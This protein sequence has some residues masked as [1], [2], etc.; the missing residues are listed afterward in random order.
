MRLAILGVIAIGCGS[1]AS[2]PAAPPSQA[3]G[4]PAARWV[5]ARPTYVFASRTVGEAQRNLRD[6]IDM[7][8]TAAGYDLHDAT[9]AVEGLFGVDPLQGASLAAIGVDLHGSWA[10]FSEAL[11]PTLVVHLAAPAQM[12]AFLE[13]QRQRGLV[14]QSTIVDTTEVFSAKLVGGVTLRWA[15]AGDWMWVHLALPLGPEDATS[16]FR[17]SHG[18]HGD[19]WTSNWAWA[20]RAAGAAAGVIGVLD[21]HGLNGLNGVN[22]LNGAIAGAIARIPG[23]LACTKLVEPVGRVAVAVAGDDHHVAAR[24]AV[25]VGSTTGIRSLILPAPSGWDATAAHAAIAAQWNLDLTAARSWLSPCLA[26]AGGQLAPLDEIPVRAARGM[27]LGFDPGAMSGSGAVA[28][29]VASPA[30]L[31]RQLDRIPLRRALERARTF[32]RYKGFSIAIPFSV[33]VEYV[34]DH[35]LALAALGEGLLAKLIAPGRGAPAPI[36]AL[37]VAPP[38]MSAKAWETVLQAVTEQSFSGSPG[39]ATKPAVERLMRWRDAHLGVTAEA[40]EL[41]VTVSGNRR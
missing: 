2:R 24:I 13:R 29:D 4:F 28:L 18:P 11:S 38:A 10:M 39:P 20:Q 31:E 7:L 16:W 30:F 9:R 5:P 33:T 21:L 26:L 23:A 27:L 35:G 22:G 19:E 12:T 1:H 32:G 6:V 40:T 14:T 8:G 37:D 34:L 25:D 17:A 15:I 3:A 36:F 41:I